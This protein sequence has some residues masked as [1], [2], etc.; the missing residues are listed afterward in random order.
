MHVPRRRTAATAGT[1]ALAGFLLVLSSLGG[2]AAGPADSSPTGRTEHQRTKAPDGESIAAYLRRTLPKGISDTVIAARGGHLAHCGGFGTADRAAGVPAGCHTV[3]D[4]MSITKQFTAAAILKL[5]VMGRLRVED[6]IGRHLGPGA[7]PG[8]KRAITVENLLTH[9]SGLAE[10]LGGDYDPV[11]RDELVRNALASKLRSAPGKGFHYSNVGYSLLAAIVEKAS[12]ESYERFLARR[13][14]APAGMRNTGYVLPRR[15]R[16]LIAVEYDAKG[17]S[18]G[19]PVDH[20]W[21]ADGPY[22]NLRGNGGMLST[23]PDMLRWS[24]A[25]SDDT[26]LPASARRRLFAPRVRVPGSDSRYAYGWNIRD[27]GTGRLAWH[28]GGNG[29]SLALLA[30]AQPDDVLI[31]WASNHAYRKGRW[32]MEDRAEELTLGLIAR[33]RA[34]EG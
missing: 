9:A 28:D 30:R 13:L 2:C 4:V 26:V 20:P 16:R 12:G 8:D 3:Y 29:W 11:S 32:N 19:R 25:L 22:W 27:L 1:A 10:G 5:D 34:G 21:A 6:R 15:P 23:A 7:V 17:R 18:Q 33:A 14:F 24:R 31:H